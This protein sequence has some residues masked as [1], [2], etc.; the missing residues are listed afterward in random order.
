[1]HIIFVLYFMILFEFHI[2]KFYEIE[3]YQAKMN[4]YINSYYKYMMEKTS[5]TSGR[6]PGMGDA[7]HNIEGNIFIPHPKL[8][9]KEIADGVKGNRNAFIM[10]LIT[11]FTPNPPVYIS[12]IEDRFNIDD[13]IKQFNSPE[14]EILVR[15][16]KYIRDNLNDF[17]NSK[18][19]YNFW[20]LF[21]MCNSIL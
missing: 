10:R 16:A 2:S 5:N 4:L 21:E 15:F 6:S 3:D 20:D 18:S 19:D 12:L 11:I 9:F 14:N 17:M 1:M 8:T 13:Y 7:K